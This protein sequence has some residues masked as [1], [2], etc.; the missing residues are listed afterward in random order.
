MTW[1]AGYGRIVLDETDSTMAEAAR[2][3]GTLAGPEWVM[4]RRQTAGRGRR[5]RAWANPEG[6]F[7]ATL[8]LQPREAPGV[9]ALRSFVAALALFDAMVAV[10]GR[11]DPFALKWPN[12]VLLN[13][14]K[15]AGILLETH[16]GGALAI[17]IGVNLVAAPDAAEVEAGAVRPVSLMAETGAAVGPEDFLDQLAQAYA[18]REA[19]FVTY[20]FAPIRE[21]WL[22]R[23][24]RLGETVTARTGTSETV[25]RF[26]TV[27]PS[28]NLV[29]MTPKGRVGI[30]AADVFF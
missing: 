16:A 23:A 18:A 10:T 15:V 7:A 8:V 3:A 11:A 17:G 29:L 20:G 1:P 2:R 14:G 4:A 28:G 9:V 30:A 22:S 13:G 26:E 25:G 19:S 21:A 27:D 5:G 12:D 24:A 6:N